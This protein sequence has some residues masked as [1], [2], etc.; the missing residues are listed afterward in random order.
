MSLLDLLLPPTCPVTGTEVTRQGALSP[1]AW[2]D[3]AFLT[4]PRCAG[5]GQ[6][7]PGLTEAEH[8]FRCDTCR[9]YDH[10]WQR[11]RAAFRYEGTGRRLIL[12]LKH[13]DRLDLVPS[14]ARWMHAAGPE[15]VAEADLV[16]PIP[17][18]WSRMLKRRY[19][20]SAELARHL[21]GIA[22]RRDAYAPG[23]LRRI[24]ATASQDG[25]DR[26]ARV[27]NLAD[28]LELTDTSRL[29]EKRVLLVDDVLTTGA[30]LAA[31]TNLCLEGGAASVDVIVSALVNF[32]EKPYVPAGTASEDLSDE[33]D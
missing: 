9:R 8:D 3:L 29:Q 24:R 2:I 21:C 18:H 28:A 20:Q 31:A 6:E 33:T 22:G 14:I 16:A 15:L 19:N 23:L 7:V 5:C 10:P 30:T 11:G 32:E 12:S 27:A 26:A 4:G 1:E 13:G 17:L 25:K